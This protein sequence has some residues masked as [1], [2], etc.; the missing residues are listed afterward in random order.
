MAKRSNIGYYE[1]SSTASS[2][3]QK[4]VTIVRKLA[5]FKRMNKTQQSFWEYNKIVETAFIVECIHSEAMRQN[6]QIGNYIEFN[7]DIFFY[8]NIF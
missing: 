5:S 2:D 1:L 6:T 7:Y 4:F 8:T 3:G